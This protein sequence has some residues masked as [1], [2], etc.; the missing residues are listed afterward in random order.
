MDIDFDQPIDRSHTESIKWHY[1][2]KDVLPMWV[3]DMDFRS[4][5][6]IIRALTER[7]Q[8][9]VFG[10]GAEPAEL[11]EIIVE[12]MRRLYGWEV[13]TEAVVFLPGV[14]TAFNLACHA[15]TCP[16]EGLLI[17]TPVYPPILHAHQPAGL[18]SD[19]NELVR[20]ADGSYQ[21]DF[22]A[23]EAAIHPHTR[24]FL[25]CNPHNPVGRVFRRDELERLAE[26]CLRHDV[27]ICSDEI[28]GDLLFGESRHIP[29]A[30]LDPAIANR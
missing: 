12:R 13:Q 3:A 23:F 28:H 15:F 26:I 5:E 11:R 20:T 19:A 7:V 18:S 1:F 24:M 10:Y 29:I 4:P 25:L 30:S 21:I 6:P 27:L 17:Q 14:V 8:H 9:G 16:G 22:D 2:D